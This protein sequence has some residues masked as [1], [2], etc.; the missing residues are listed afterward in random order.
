M[1]EADDEPAATEL[2]YNRL[3][4]DCESTILSVLIL[5]YIV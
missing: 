2:L 4:S 3:D 1:V 5:E